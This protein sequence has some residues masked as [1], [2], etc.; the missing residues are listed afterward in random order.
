MMPIDYSNVEIITHEYPELIQVSEYEF[1]KKWSIALRNKIPSTVNLETLS[2][3]LSFDGHEVNLERGAD[4]NQLSVFVRTRFAQTDYLMF[5]DW[6]LMAEID[7]LLNGIDKIQGQERQYWYPWLSLKVG[8]KTTLSR[9]VM[10]EVQ[11][12]LRHNAQDGFQFFGHLEVN[13]LIEGGA[14]VISVH[15]GGAITRQSENDVENC[16]FEMTGFF[17]LV[18]L[19][20]Y[21]P[22]LAKDWILTS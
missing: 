4:S 6:N 8:E 22:S 5:N 7:Y 1:R 11:V 12:G 14:K 3:Q 16:T 17:S 2:S 21:E 15:S 19:L 18:R 10:R 9:W 20:E 13:E